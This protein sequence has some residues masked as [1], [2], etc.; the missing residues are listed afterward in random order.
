MVT[1]IIAH[2]ETFSWLPPGLTDATHLS[3]SLREIEDAD[4]QCD[5]PQKNTEANASVDEDSPPVTSSSGE[6]YSIGSLY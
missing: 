4:E 2:N 1:S 3:I 6:G 5:N